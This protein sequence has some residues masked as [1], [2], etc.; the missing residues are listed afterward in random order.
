MPSQKRN[1]NFGGCFFVFMYVAGGLV[2]TVLGYLIVYTI[3]GSD[4]LLVM[5]DIIR[6]ISDYFPNLAGLNAF[7]AERN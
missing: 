6:V 3:N 1:T 4:P 2:G 5:P 7:L